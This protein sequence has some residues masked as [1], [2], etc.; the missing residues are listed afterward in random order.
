MEIELDGLQKGIDWDLLAKRF[1]D[2]SFLLTVHPEP[3]L[4]LTQDG[5]GYFN[6]KGIKGPI[7][8]EDVAEEVQAWKES[9]FLEGIDILY[10]YGIGLGYYYESLK[11]WLSER[12]ERVLVF[13]E[14]DLSLLK[15]LFSLP[16]GLD[17]L[18]NPQ[19]HVRYISDLSRGSW[20]LILDECVRTWISDK[21]DLSALRSYSFFISKKIKALRLSLLRKASLVHVGISELLHYHVLMKNITANILSVSDSFHVNQMAGKFKNVPAIIC[22]AG[23]SLSEVL[24]LLKK[25]EQKAL[26]FAGGSAITALGY[27]GIKPHISMALDPNDEEYVRLKGSSSFEDVFIYSSRL[28]KEVL[29][30]SNFKSGYLCS[31]TGG[32]FETWMHD[33]IG[34]GTESLGSELGMEALSVTTLAAPLAKHLGCNPI[35]FCG[36]DLSYQNQ[37]RYV[38]GVLPSST[39]FLDDLHQEERSM[40]KLVRRK[41]SEGVFVQSL[42]KWVMEASCLGLYAKN[43]TETQFFNASSKGLPIPNIP[44]LSIEEFIDRY[45]QKEYDLRGLLHGESEAVSFSSVSKETI[46]SLF[47][48]LLDSLKKCLSIET[49]MLQQIDERIT[50]I[51]DLLV[52]LE[53][54]KMS[55]LE[56]DLADEPAYTACLQYAFA[57]YPRMIERCYPSLGSL[58][59][60]EGRSAFLKRKKRLWQE[61]FSVTKECKELLSKYL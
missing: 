24:P 61:C 1:P 22:G 10:V 19:V 55:L 30:S 29:L 58:D 39:V 37:E 28:N 6:V 47:R 34:I 18:Q 21:V 5:R 52:P 44:L 59:S 50:L 8:S 38:P 11:S 56:M 49:Q 13:F 4:E 36:V 26:I 41:N 57:V 20:D 9:L 60:I 46:R 15:E 3:S 51:S 43:T 27:Y 35:L 53:S 54:G 48:V 42:V 23:V 32:S 2:I 31:D 16:L 25:L 12:P 45:C 40:E 17:L 33:Q 7:Y 14:D